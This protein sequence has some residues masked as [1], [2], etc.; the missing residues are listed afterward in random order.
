MSRWP[1]FERKV[2]RFFLLISGLTLAFM[3]VFTVFNVIMRLF[4]R[5]IVGDYEIISFLG[6]IV[7]GFA[8]PYTAWVK[9]HVT[10]DFVLDRL[11]KRSSAWTQAVTRFLSAALFVWIGWNFIA[12]SL[13][14]IKTKEVT[15]LLKVPYYPIS[16]ALALCCFLLSV[17]LLSQI[18]KIIGGKHE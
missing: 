9:G 12:L 15:Q 17:T 5:P 4:R 2:N 7:V 16:F 14:L 1:A 6:A 13:D 18:K 8:L 10:V 11:S 3:L